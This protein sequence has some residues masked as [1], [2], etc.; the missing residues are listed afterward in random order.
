MKKRIAWC[1]ATALV[2][3]CGEPPADYFPGYAEAEYVRVATPI[4]GTLVKL[5]V[6]RGDQVEQHAPA[7][8]LEQESERAA[9]EEAAARVA[10]ATAQLANLRKGRRPEEIAALQAQLAQAKAAMA[11]SSSNFARKKKLVA[12]QFIS[13]AGLDEA[14]TAVERD[15]ARVSELRAQLRVARLGARSDEIAAAQQE[16][17]SAEAIL[18]QAEWKLAQKTQ[19]MPAPGLVNDVLYREGEFVPAGSP[20]VSLLPPQHIKLRFFVPEASLGT[21][22][23]GQEVV[24]RCDGCASPVPARISYVSSSPEYTSPLIYSKENRATLVFMLEA[25][26]APEQ[27]TLLHPGQPVEIRLAGTKADTKSGT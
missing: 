12:D 20:V 27:A 1:L 7:F 8:V 16:L 18:A 26:P 23:I 19:R 13:P 11:L 5:H 2:A 4:A 17:K 25:R 22:R 14:R 10:R 24:A 15:Q 6:Q 3:G 9:R 21:L